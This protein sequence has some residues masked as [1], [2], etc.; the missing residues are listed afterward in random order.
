MKTDLT[1]YDRRIIEKDRRYLTG[2]ENGKPVWH[3]SQYHAWWDQENGGRF[4]AAVARKVGG[5]VRTFNPITGA[6]V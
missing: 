5:Q 6:I 3:W 2:A 4:V 1:A